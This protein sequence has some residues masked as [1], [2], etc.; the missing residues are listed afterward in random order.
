MSVTTADAVG[1]KRS[2]TLTH[3]VLYGIGVTIGA[4]IYVLIGA[5]AGRAGMTAPLAF[6]LAAILMALSACSFAELG[7]RMPVAASEAA[8]VR[9]GLRSAP[10]ALVVGLLV[11]A[12]AVISAA[13]ISVGSAG[14]LRVF[15]PLPEPV[16]IA[17]VVA[18]MGAIACF[19]IRESVSFAGLMTLIE[20][21][22]LVILVAAGLVQL[23]GV[24]TRLPEVLPQGPDAGRLWVGVL[25]AGLLAVFAFIGFEGIVNVA[26]EIREPER[27]IPRALFITLALTTLLYCSVIWIALLAVGPAALAQSKAPLAVVF[28]RLTG[29]SPKLMSAIAVVATLN[30]I[31]VQIIMGSRV[32]YGLASQG[33]LPARLAAVS[34]L[35]QTP[36][37]ATLVMVALTMAFALLMPLDRLADLTSRIALALFALVNLSLGLI[38][39]R[40]DPAPARAFVAPG[41]VPWAGLLATLL[42]LAADLLG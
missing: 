28:E 9:A 19:G 23:E 39:L 13:A 5:A 22:G 6:V 25:G 31:I 26:E 32:T 2:L 16:V 10:A 24:A 29:A 37:A 7:S 17:T 18:L 1:L 35:T 38:K 4:G 12:M 42:L 14:Y 21:G 11:I 27:T 8:Y 36:L 15:L 30:G 40:G 33:A 20:V 34:P 41:W 3:V